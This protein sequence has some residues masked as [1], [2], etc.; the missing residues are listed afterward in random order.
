MAGFLVAFASA[1]EVFAR[2]GQRF[3]DN[4]IVRFYEYVREN[5]LFVSYVIVPPQIDGSKPTH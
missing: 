2:R 1:L 5:D 4:N 3:A